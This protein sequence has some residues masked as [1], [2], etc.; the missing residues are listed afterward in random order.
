MTTLRM[1]GRAAL[2]FLVLATLGALM[3]IHA[4]RAP[5]AAGPPPEC[6]IDP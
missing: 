6:H 1:L 2:A 5:R 3:S 4:M